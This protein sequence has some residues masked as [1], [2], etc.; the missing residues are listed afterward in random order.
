MSKLFKGKLPPPKPVA[1]KKYPNHNI[2][3]RLELYRKSLEMKG[4]QFSKHIG[5]SQGSYSDLKNNR[6]SPSCNT[7]IQIINLGECDIIW[8]LTG[9]K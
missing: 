7:I 2:G 1:A 8:L 9:K 5:I 6:S 4:F 3:S